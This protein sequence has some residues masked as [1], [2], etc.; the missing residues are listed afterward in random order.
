MKPAALGVGLRL[1]A[2]GAEREVAAIAS[3]AAGVM[4]RRITVRGTKR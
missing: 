4:A 2:D 1:I 3:K